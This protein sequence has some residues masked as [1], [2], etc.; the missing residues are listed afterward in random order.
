M[1]YEEL[2][3]HCW[4]NVS[5]LDTE[6]VAKA[7]AMLAQKFSEVPEFA[8]ELRERITEKRF[9]WIGGRDEIPCFVCK[10]EGVL[11][12]LKPEIEAQVR[13]DDNLRYDDEEYEAAL[14][15]PENRGEPETCPHCEGTKVCAEPS[16]HHGWGT[17]IRNLLRQEGFG[18]PYFGIDNLDDF[19][20]VFIE[21]ALGFSRVQA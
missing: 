6:K 2:H 15:I 17:S 20:V 14:A 18:E 3:Q 5:H 13:Y 10:A 19:Y 11:Q 16:L 9:G 7:V 8:K 12:T 1:T 4:N 21:M